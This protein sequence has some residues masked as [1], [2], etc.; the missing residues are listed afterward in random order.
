MSIRLSC[1]GSV[2]LHAKVQRYE[3]AEIDQVGGKRGLSFLGKE[4][5]REEEWK[6]CSG[7]TAHPERPATSFLSP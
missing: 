2:V 3:T 1:Q 4:A 6:H 7:D 5:G